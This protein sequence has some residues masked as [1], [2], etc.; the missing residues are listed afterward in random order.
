MS[1]ETM[2]HI[3]GIALVI[4]WFGIIAIFL[5]DIIDEDIWAGTITLIV[6]VVDVIF[7]LLFFFNIFIVGFFGLLA[8]VLQRNWRKIENA[9]KERRKN[10]K[11]VTSK[12]EQNLS[13][14]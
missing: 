13:K 8:F 9:I 2:G 10:K 3:G 4:F 1:P 6:I 12:R 11:A 7:S 5:D 14:K